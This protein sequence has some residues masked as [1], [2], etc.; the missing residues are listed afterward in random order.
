M[1]ETETHPHNTSGKEQAPMLDT[2]I[3]LAFCC[4]L[5][6]LSLA[7]F[8]W[9]IATRELFTLDN[10]SLVLIDLTVG[11]MFMANIAWS[12]HTGEVRQIL[13]FYRK[14]ARRNEAPRETPENAK[15]VA[16]DAAA[17]R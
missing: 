13:D 5:S 3:L 16:P 15:E 8:I 12:A 7:V 6:L 2:V 1:S 9:V 11:A 17:R 10:L 14:K 4:L